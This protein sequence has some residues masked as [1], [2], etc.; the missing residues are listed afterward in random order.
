MARPIS[1]VKK[2]EIREM[3]L[4]GA[5]YS[6]IMRKVGCTKSTVGYHARK[7]GLSSK[8]KGPSVRY[9]WAAVGIAYD[10]GLSRVECSKRFG[11]CLGSWE[12]AKRSG[13]LVTHRDRHLQLSVLLVEDRPQ[14]GRANL[15]RK[16]VKEG[17]LEYKCDRCGISEW[18]GA[19][20]ALQL[21][22][23]NGRKTDNRLS[24]VRL[25]CP[26]CHSQTDT[27]AGRNRKRTGGSSNGKIPASD[28]G[29]GGS[30]PPLPTL[31]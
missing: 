3:L 10:S 19:P 8:A 18:L 31:N 11:F 7:M 1:N 13:R 14:T 28:A 6:A 22:H 15:K 9:D 2:C 5:V 23:V 29:H 4:T 26:N 16:L 30:N 17:V 12:K 25:L 24:N 20:L 27:F 21:D